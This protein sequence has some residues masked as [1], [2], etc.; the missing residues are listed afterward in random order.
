VGDNASGANAQ[1]LATRKGK[2]L[3]LNPDGSIPADNPFFTA[4]AGDNRAIWALG[5]RNPFTYAFDPAS[6]RMAVNDVGESAW[7]EIDEG[8]AG[9]NYGWPATEGPTSDP[10]FRGPV[11]A[12]SHGTGCAI[13]GAAF[14]APSTRTFPAAYAGSYFFADLCSGWIG[15]LDPATGTVSGFA[16]GLPLPVDL[17]VGPDGALY[18]LARG[19]GGAVGRIQYA[20]TGGGDGTGLRGDYYDNLPSPRFR[21][22]RLDP[23][24]SFDWG[25][26]S[27]DPALPADR[28]GVRWTG[29]IVPRYSELYR[30]YTVADDGVQLWVNGA[31]VVSEWSD[32]AARERSG[33][34]PLVAGQ[35]YDLR[36][37]YYENTGAASVQLLWS[38]ASQPKEVV[39][40][41]QLFPP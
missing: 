16:S 35:P 33:T 26:G 34:I 14:Y 3:R 39:P 8:I 36:I 30:L 38:S 15:R 37:E 7:E 22:A 2:I 40:R 23:A 21:G 41:G 24:V 32:G 18:Y 17:Q 9:A 12:Y 25:G 11:F 4:A 10:R 13:S 28:F 20:S 27:P 5:L 29:R 19:G 1:S 6:G 31:L